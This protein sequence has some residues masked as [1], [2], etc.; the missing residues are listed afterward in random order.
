MH[1]LLRMI[2]EKMGEIKLNLARKWRSKQFETIVGQETSV[3]MLKNSLF[4]QQFFPVYLFSGQRGCGKT[5]TARVFAAAL[6]CMG[7][8]EFQENPKKNIVP[9]QMCASCVA[10]EQ[11]KHPDFIEI[12]AASHTGVDNVRM[13]ID[14][15]SLLPLMGT[16]KIYLIDE[17][18]MLSKAAFN[19]LLK[20]LEEPPASVIFM[21]AT[22]DPHKIIETVR[23]RCFQLFFRSVD[24]DILFK[25]LQRVCES[26]QINYDDAG[27]YNI[28]GQTEGSVRDALNLLETVRFSNKKVTHAAVSQMLGRMDDVAI[29]ALLRA[30]LSGNA[31]TILQLIQKL[32]WHQYAAPLIWQRL[33]ELTRAALWIKYGVMPDQF[34]EH[35]ESIKKIIQTSSVQQLTRFMRSMYDRELLFAKTTAKHDV[36]EMVLL[37]LCSLIKKTSSDGG[38]SASSQLAATMEP[39]ADDFDDGDESSDEQDDEEEIEEE[40]GL[41][42]WG[43]FVRSICELDDPLISSVFQQ[44]TVKLHEGTVLQVEFSKELIF[45]KEWIENAQNLWMPLLQKQFGVSVTFQPL[46]TG[47]KAAVTPSGVRA[48]QRVQSKPVAKPVQK[49]TPAPVQKNN[50]QSNRF[51]KRSA[52]PQVRIFTN[53]H[54]ID[55]SDAAAWPVAHMVKKHLSGT[56]TELRA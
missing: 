20:I 17:A 5:S 28:I 36:L 53:E 32:E 33:L 22:T 48:A 40:E 41:G 25:Q 31:A 37:S 1:H 54:A 3:R 44:G 11:G 21:L 45:F 50:Y 24:K 34:L 39:P 49:P 35:V 29:I 47:Q 51:A 23:S 26:E 55:T 6:N 4:L 16:K 9:C 56:I 38:G 52:R 14:S 10:M 18:H 8:S 30:A 12:D 15:A 43:R 27:L 13:L 7:L 46:F 2:G 19:A 42:L